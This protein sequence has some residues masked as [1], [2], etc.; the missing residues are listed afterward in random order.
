MKEQKNTDLLKL[1]KEQIKI[2]EDLGTVDEAFHK[3]CCRTQR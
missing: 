3:C 2:L 1:L